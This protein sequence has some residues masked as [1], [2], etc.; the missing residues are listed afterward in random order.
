MLDKQGAVHDTEAQQEEIEEENEA[1]AQE[2]LS[3][4]GI[5][6]TWSMLA[7]IMKQSGLSLRVGGVLPEDLE[8]TTCSGNNQAR[9]HMSH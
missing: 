2:E 5:L 4:W 8:V 3:S 6:L 7:K 1:E 9:H